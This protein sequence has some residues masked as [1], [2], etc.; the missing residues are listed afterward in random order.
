MAIKVLDIRSMSYTGTSWLNTVL[1]C[2]K[3][4]LAMG[5]PDRFNDLWRDNPGALCLVHGRECEL[6]PRFCEQYDPA[7]GFFEQLSDFTGRTVFV[8]NNPL[9]DGFGRELE[10]PGVEA[11]RIYLVRD[12]RAV[13]A[14][15]ARHF[16]VPLR[17]AIAT[18]TA[19]SLRSFLNSYN[20]NPRNLFR[21]ED[22]RADPDAA[23]ARIGR[24]AGLEFP[25]NAVRY[26][27]FEHHLVSAN[28]GMIA[29]IKLHQ[30]QELTDDWDGLAF[31]QEQVEREKGDP[32]AG[33]QDDRWN[34]E[35][36]FEDQ[37]FFEAQCGSLNARLGYPR[38]PSRLAYWRH[39]LGF[40]KRAVAAEPAPEPAG[41]EP[42]FV[43]LVEDFARLEK[44]AATDEPVEEA[45]QTLE[46]YAR[47]EILASY[48]A[49]LGALVRNRCDAF[50]GSRGVDFGCWYGFSTQILARLGAARV[51]GLDV[52]ERFVRI[53]E[54]CAELA[55]ADGVDFEVVDNRPFGPVPIEDASVDWVVANDLFSYA[56]PAIFPLMI[57][58]AA[59]I[60]KPGGRFFLSDANN[61]H[62]SSV[63]ERL[64][65]TYRMYELGLGT[66]E[67]PKGT[68]W[69]WRTIM[70]K[71]RYPDLDEAAIAGL[72][73]DTAYLWGDELLERAEALVRSP[74]TAAVSRYVPDS[75]NVAIHPKD[76]RSFG[77]PTDPLTLFAEF[78]KAGLR[79][80]LRVLGQ[81]L[82]LADARKQIASIERFDLEGVKP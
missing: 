73:A 41:P 16:D 25:T 34:N 27:D 31:Y 11:I 58:E 65:D 59:R 54:R 6:W 20:V 4:A 53:A 8:L 44:A 36:S 38:G 81:D 62:N 42:A 76:G 57:A 72:A 14:S 39:R 51:T 49:H 61:P 71:E 5:P 45:R 28:R 33:F 82:A 13:S 46:H 64:V 69:L 1:G 52:L 80:Q 77:A 60:L 50:A 66:A 19:P 21:Y 23:I 22:L 35:Y 74:D 7:T 63:R 32:R 48:W 26:W 37:R 29:C 55:E 67:E 17:E 3:L 18:W 68:C 40:G 70:L 2:H 24:L 79:P 15:Y 43:A 10:R 30:G 12:A 56:N 78:E 9:P 47:E 75:M